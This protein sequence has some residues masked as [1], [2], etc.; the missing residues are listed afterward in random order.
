[1]YWLDRLID[2]LCISCMS[3]PV[4]L[5][6]VDAGSLSTVI[7]SWSQLLQLCRRCGAPRRSAPWLDKACSTCNYF[8]SSEWMYERKS[9][10][11]LIFLIYS[12]HRW[13]VWVRVRSQLF[14]R[15]NRVG[16][17]RPCWPLRSQLSLCCLHHSGPHQQGCGPPQ[18]RIKT[19]SLTVSRF[20]SKANAHFHQ[21]WH[22]KQK[23]LSVTFPSL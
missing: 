11:D 10:L 3:C 17:L 8:Y 9:H 13:H 4:Q 21:N 6:W 19:Q 18:V 15:D 5:I 22:N 20:A 23:I 1:M 2:I 14:R 7:V 16:R 12:T